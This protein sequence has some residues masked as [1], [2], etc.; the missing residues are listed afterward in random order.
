MSE[1]DQFVT[2]FYPDPNPDETIDQP[3]RVLDKIDHTAHFAA[4]I[5]AELD[6]TSSPTIAMMWVQAQEA[7][8]QS[9]RSLV[10]LNPFESDE[11][12]AKFIRVQ[13]DARRF[14]DMFRW[15][16]E[17][18]ATHR[19]WVEYNQDKEVQR[20]RAETERANDRSND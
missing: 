19:R 9:V 1:L 4:D 12:K 10:S 8:V 16:S 17:Q 20:I 15:L 13:N 18:A 11:E 3:Q 5:L 6:E 14:L 2:M 7:Y